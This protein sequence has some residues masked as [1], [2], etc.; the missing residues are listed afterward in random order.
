MAKRGRKPKE[1]SERTGYFYETEEDAFVNYLKSND[2][3]QITGNVFSDAL[4]DVWIDVSKLVLIKKA[5]E[6]ENGV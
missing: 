2:K 4:G 3:I 1:K 6:K 5:S